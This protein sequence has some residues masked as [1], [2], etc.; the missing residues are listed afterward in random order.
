MKD[1]A[2]YDVPK[3]LCDFVRGSETGTATGVLDV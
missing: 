1:D 3:T 2:P